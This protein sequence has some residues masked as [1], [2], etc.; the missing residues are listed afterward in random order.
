MDKQ[1]K[2]VMIG[3]DIF[4]WIFVLVPWLVWAFELVDV[5]KNGGNFEPGFFGEKHFA[6]G[7]NAVWEEIVLIKDFGGSLW[8]LFV[9]FT[10][11]YTIFLVKRIKKEEHQ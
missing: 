2:E 11:A 9:L 4:L 5:Y 7:W 3:I 1:K 10:L 6:I 8:V